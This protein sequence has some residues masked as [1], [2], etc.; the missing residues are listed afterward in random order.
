[1]ASKQMAADK[2][3]FY[4]RGALGILLG[5]IILVW[6]GLTLLSLVTFLSIW[7]LLSGVISI[8]D[9]VMSINKGGMGWLGELLLGIFEL[10]VGA[11]LVQRP[12]LTGL[13][14]ITLIGAV[15]ILQGLVYLMRTFMESS[16]SSGRRMLSL[17]FAVVAFI[18]GIWLWRYPVHGSLAFVW[19]IGLYAIVSGTLLIALGS[20]AE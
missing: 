12:G 16:A 2:S 8:I 17:I 11:Y 6:P 3:Y 18:A 13:T 9:G 19:L 1:M 7:L 4:W 15:F 5:V 20:E 10:G 14:I